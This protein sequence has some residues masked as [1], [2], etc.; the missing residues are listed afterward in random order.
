MRLPRLMS[1]RG[2]E[3]ANARP[4]ITPA[5]PQG[6]WLQRLGPFLRA[7]RWRIAIAVAASVIGQVV[8][9]LTPV[10]EK[11]I[12]DDT[13]V[14]PQPRRSGRCSPCSSAPRWSPSSSPSPAARSAAG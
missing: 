11:V 10:I 6:G 2:S 3:E 1:T 12:V 8:V 13:L 7:H 9:A 14:E 4:V 5:A